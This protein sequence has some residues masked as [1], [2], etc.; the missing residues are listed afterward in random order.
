MNYNWIINPL[1]LLELFQNTDAI[2]FIWSVLIIALLFPSI[3]FFASFFEF[4]IIH[5]VVPRVLTADN[6]ELYTYICMQQVLTVLI[7]VYAVKQPVGRV[8]DSDWY[9]LKRTSDGRLDG[10]GGYVQLDLYTRMIFDDEELIYTRE[11]KVIV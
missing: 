5:L 10:L 6:K 3:F 1:I 8:N 7:P 2:L 11:V 4:F 9:L